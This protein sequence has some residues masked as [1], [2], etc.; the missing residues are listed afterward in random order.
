MVLATKSVEQPQSG[1][2]FILEG[3]PIDKAMCKAGILLCC[4]MLCLCNWTSS[5][6]LILREV[7]E[8][9]LSFVKTPYRG[10][11]VDI[12]PTV[13]DAD[14]IW[15]I[16]MNTDS[17]EEPLVL[18]HGLGAGVAL[19]VLNLDSFAKYRPVYAMDV[20]GFGRSS[21]PTFSKDPLISEKQ[22]VKSVEEWR[23]KMN[24]NRMVLLGH[25][26]G[27]FIASSYALSYPERVSHLILADPW[28]FP[29][30]PADLLTTKPLWQRALV[31]AI[32]PLNPLWPLRAAGPFGQW[33]LQKTRADIAHKFKTAV[34]DN[35][36]V[37][38]QYIHQCNVQ[39]PS[40]ESAFHAMMALFGW[41]K[42]PME[43]RLKDLRVDIPITFI[44]G[45]ESW[46]DSSSG[47]T[48]KAHR[49][50]SIVDIKMVDGAGHHVYADK[51][52]IFN[53][54]V[55]EACEL[56]K[57][58]ATNIDVRDTTESDKE[59][60]DGTLQTETQ[61]ITVHRDQNSEHTLSDG[62]HTMGLQQA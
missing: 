23:R 25:S 21:R 37:I 17:E 40:G 52:D 6:I 49:V 1:R 41:A 9:I 59:V 2:D 34:E 48:I 43:H 51:A 31:N 54:Y 60:N 28:G 56:Y 36:K 50:D 46:M 42:Y 32:K 24:I 5:S 16:S 29:E 27:G 55:N 4:V 26:M 61:Q 35:T 15:T 22:L 19:W 30:M 62:Q 11:F 44:Y 18:L 13:G 7:E 58:S 38:P 14:K 57:A 20:L 33:M 53:R 10:F 39:K 3:K 8:K 45:S 12:G 47:E